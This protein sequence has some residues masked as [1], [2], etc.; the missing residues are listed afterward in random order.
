MF[1]HEMHYARN[2]CRSQ[3]LKPSQGSNSND[4]KNSENLPHVFER[5]SCVMH[6][7][8]SPPWIALATYFK[9]H[10]LY[11]MWLLHTPCCCTRQQDHHTAFG[12]ILY[13]LMVLLGYQ[14]LRS[15]APSLHQSG[16]ETHY[17]WRTNKVKSIW[18]GKRND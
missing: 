10:T 5:R 13:G 7:C 15:P 2:T 3:S 8:N 16:F 14:V 9:G 12:Y 1:D 11:Y 17:P 4:I 18:L 6:R